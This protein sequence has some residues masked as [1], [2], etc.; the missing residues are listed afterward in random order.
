MQNEVYNMQF[1][2][3]MLSDLSVQWAIM[4]TTFEQGTLMAKHLKCLNPYTTMAYPF[5]GWFRGFLY[6]GNIYI[7]TSTS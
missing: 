5:L 1:S 7:Y 6:T 2:I 3:I 4:K